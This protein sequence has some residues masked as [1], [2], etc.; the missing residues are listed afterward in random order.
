MLPR[1]TSLTYSRAICS[2]EN[3][4]FITG[5][6]SPSHPYI[7]SPFATG[8]PGRNCIC[9]EMTYEALMKPILLFLQEKWRLFAVT[10]SRVFTPPSESSLREFDSCS[11]HPGMY[12]LHAD[13]SP[14]LYI[15]IELQSKC[16]LLVISDNSKHW[17]VAAAVTKSSPEPPL[18]R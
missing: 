18:S 12:H 11:T 1:Q 4:A 7:T 10:F 16:T 2:K 8:P 15:K 3:V 6:T 17:R 9:K 13:W 14:S 5:G